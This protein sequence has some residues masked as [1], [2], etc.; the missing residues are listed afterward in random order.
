[1]TPAAA[2]KEMIAPL[3]PEVIHRYRIPNKQTDRRTRMHEHT[4]TQIGDT[5]H[6]HV[7]SWLIFASHRA[8]CD[9]HKPHIYS[10]KPYGLHQCGSTQTTAT[11]KT[12]VI[13]PP[14]GCVMRLKLSNW[15]RELEKVQVLIPIKSKQLCSPLYEPRQKCSFL[16]KAEWRKVFKHLWFHLL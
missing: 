14:I 13:R 11:I 8:G 15:C 1:M 6:C 3:S 5:L 9:H 10:R 4:H 7:N 16:G 2:N 12:K